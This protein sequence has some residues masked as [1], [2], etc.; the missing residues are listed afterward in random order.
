MSPTNFKLHNI[1]QDPKQKKIIRQFFLKIIPKTLIQIGERI[2]L[3]TCE[4]AS[5]FLTHTFEEKNDIA[6]L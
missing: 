6:H 5:D 4:P 2:V 3:H 1:L